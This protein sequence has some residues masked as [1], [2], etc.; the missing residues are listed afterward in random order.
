MTMR[1]LEKGTCVRVCARYRRINVARWSVRKLSVRKFA[2]KF[3]Q[4]ILL[5]VWPADDF[6]RSQILGPQPIF[7]RSEV[8]PESGAVQSG[9]TG[10]LPKCLLP[11][12]RRAFL[13][14]SPAEKNK[15]QSLMLHFSS[16]VTVKF[17]L[18]QFFIFYS[19]VDAHDRIIMI[20]MVIY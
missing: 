16:I 11:R 4:V 6:A 15:M 2:R 3:E 13:H 5:T 12:D 1:M 14:Q 18:F 7:Q 20:K 8:L 17:L 9:L 10:G 19:T